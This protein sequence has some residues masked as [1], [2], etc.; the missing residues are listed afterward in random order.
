[1][2]GL[3]VAEERER[4]A[5]RR[6]RREERQAAADEAAE[7]EIERREE[8][9][10]LEAEWIADTQLQLSQ[11]SYLDGDGSLPEPGS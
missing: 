1:M 8:E 7:K 5:S 9:K 3:E 6:R 10:M 2:T 11:L 4:D